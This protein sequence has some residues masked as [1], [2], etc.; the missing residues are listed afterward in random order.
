MSLSV[1]LF[2]TASAGWLWFVFALVC[3]FED[4]VY[5]VWGKG[6]CFGEDEMWYIL[7]LVSLPTTRAKRRT[8]SLLLLLPLS[9]PLLIYIPR[10]K[11]L[12]DLKRAIPE[13]LGR[14]APRVSELVW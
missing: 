5:K 2:R 11:S 6:V 4:E 8:S 7:R 9:S 14:I 3:A 1:G 12:G 13:L 10:T